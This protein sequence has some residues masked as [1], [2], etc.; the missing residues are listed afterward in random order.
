MLRRHLIKGPYAIQQ[1]GTGAVDD[2]DLTNALFHGKLEHVMV[3]SF[4]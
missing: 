1:P 4:L 2:C 3:A